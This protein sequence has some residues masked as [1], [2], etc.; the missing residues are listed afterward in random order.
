MTETQNNENHPIKIAKM[1]EWG[2]FKGPLKQHP[3]H[4]HSHYKHPR[5]RRET[6][7]GKNVFD[8]FLSE[9]FVTKYGQR[10]MKVHGPPPPF[11]DLEMRLYMC[12][13]VFMYSPWF[14]TYYMV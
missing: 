14:T 4:L 6:E 1:N 3:G 2:K 12:M 11:S 5:R 8:V 9:S 7:T 10:S 13:H